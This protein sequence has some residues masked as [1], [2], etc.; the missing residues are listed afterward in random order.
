MSITWSATLMMSMLCSITS[1]VLPWSTKRSS[2]L[3]SCCHV[4]EVQAGGGL[5]EDVEGVPG[6]AL[7]QFG[8]QLDALGLAS[9]QGGGRSDPA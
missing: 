6:V 4:L 8:G 7:A 1:T 3:I 5:V 2:T 9:G